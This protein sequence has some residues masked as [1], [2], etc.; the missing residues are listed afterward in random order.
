MPRSRRTLGFVALS[1]ASLLAAVAFVASAALG[2]SADGGGAAASGAGGAS[3]I[4]F[5]SRDASD[6]EG[7]GR[8]ASVPVERPS[9]ARRGTGRRC[10]RAYYTRTRGLCLAPRGSFLLT[11]VAEILGTG[12]D[13]RHTV[14]LSG[15]PS[16]ARI[17]PDGRLGAVT[18]FVQ[19]HSYAA[20]GA[21]STRTVLIDMERGAEL[22]ELE[23]FAV[24]RDGERIRAR[25]VNFWGVTFAEDSNRFFA[26]LATGGKTY[27]IEGDVAARSATVRHEN[28][29]CPSL[30]PDG[31][32][33]AYKKLVERPGVWRLHV[34]DLETM[35]ETAL[36][37]TR[38][39]DDQ[40][41][42]LD[43]RRV[44]YGT[45]NDVWTAPAD[46]SGKPSVLIADADSPA[47]AR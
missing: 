11:Y 14:K 47:V 20:E 16:R 17:S 38:S 6:P 33:I 1:A 46:G 12:P 37:E 10:E 5:R 31:T 45:E 4:L 8:V 30:S 26:T 43:D 15:F 13:V 39:V 21:F 22:A 35:R 9:G 7:N 29:E 2:G 19:G 27:L 34:L 3:Q 28:V 25:D 36:A 44:L 42:W 32:R 40:V 23:E 18:T 41:E 24:V